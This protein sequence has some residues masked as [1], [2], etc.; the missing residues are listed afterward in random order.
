MFA[1]TALVLLGAPE[2]P[3][4]VQAYRWASFL[5]FT[6]DGAYAAYTL[7]ERHC[8]PG[9]IWERQDAVVVEVATATATRYTLALEG[10]AA[11]F[12]KNNRP[13]KEFEA[14]KKAHPVSGEAASVNGERRAIVEVKP[15]SARWRKG[16]ARFEPDERAGVCDA[17]GKCTPGPSVFY[18]IGD[19]SNA[20]PIF[21]TPMHQ[22][23]G[24]YQPGRVEV[25]WSADGKRAAFVTNWGWVMP[26]NP[27]HG[28]VLFAPATGPRLEL[29]ADAKFSDAAAMAA[30]RA[31]DAAGIVV[32]RRGKAKVER[33]LSVVY[34]AKGAED[35]AAKVAAAVPG[36]ASVEPLTWKADAEVVLALGASAAK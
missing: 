36:G 16:T 21:S 5:G 14:W 10:S 4:E 18:S 32:L 34:A 13:A 26:E 20:W 22:S 12:R 7:W 33:E 29:V 6:E 3:G 25:F 11:G 8:E 2:F 17:S 24:G 9:E 19:A 35:F 28:E 1:L 30:M 23:A 31:L 27:G 15:G